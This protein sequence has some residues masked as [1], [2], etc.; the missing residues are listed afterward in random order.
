VSLCVG[1]N[2][3]IPFLLVSQSSLMLL[4]ALS[5]LLDFS[6]VR[7]SPSQLQIIELLLTK[8]KASFK[9]LNAEEVCM[10]PTHRIIAAPPHPSPQPLTF[11]L[12]NFHG[13]TLFPSPSPLGL[14]GCL[15]SHLDPVP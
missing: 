14:H 12:S 7:A 1:A 15:F 4:W 10:H 6:D 8:L 11:G 13:P 2:A 5:K 3:C 9:L